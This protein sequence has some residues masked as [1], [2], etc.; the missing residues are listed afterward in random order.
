MSTA[1]VATNTGRLDVLAQEIRQH[2]AGAHSHA[3]TAIEHKLAIG[4]RLLEAKSILP[5]AS[6]LPWARAEFSWTPRHLQR[7]MQLAKA[8]AT[9]VSHLPNSASWRLVLAMA[10]PDDGGVKPLRL[11]EPKLVYAFASC[12]VFIRCGCGQDSNA[13][14]ELSEAGN[15]T[16]TC[17]K[18]QGRYT[19]SATLKGVRA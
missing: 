2:D 14:I 15:G 16:F 13:A 1:L 3:E 4:A 12:T 19:V 10:V 18:C 17:P 7:H 5:H 6:F 8:N 11:L 9:R